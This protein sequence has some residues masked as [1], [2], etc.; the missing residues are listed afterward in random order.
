MKRSKFSEAQV[1][2]ILRQ[3]DEGAYCRVAGAK[4]RNLQ[5]VTLSAAASFAA[6]VSAS[7]NHGLFKSV[8]IR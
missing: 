2:F 8:R 1:S 3:V 7:V 5:H 4:D 6:F